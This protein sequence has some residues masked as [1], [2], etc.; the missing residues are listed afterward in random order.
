MKT[1][2][3]HHHTA[4]TSRNTTGGPASA[5]FSDLGNATIFFTMAV[6][7]TSRVHSGVVSVSP[8]SFPMRQSSI[9]NTFKQQQRI[10][11]VRMMFHES[12]RTLPIYHQLSQRRQTPR[13]PGGL[14]DSCQESCCQHLWDS[15]ECTQSHVSTTYKTPSPRMRF[16]SDN[17]N[18]QRHSRSLSPANRS[19]IFHRTYIHANLQYK[20]SVDSLQFSTFHD[21]TNLSTKKDDRYVTF[22][23]K[24][25][26][27]SRENNNN[28]TNNNKPT[29]RYLS[30]CEDFVKSVQLHKKEQEKNKLM[31]E[32]LEYY[33]RTNH[34]LNYY[35]HGDRELQQSESVLQHNKSLVDGFLT[36][37]GK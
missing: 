33:K 35:L 30:A 12:S 32:R 34:I 2:S 24:S 29:K 20:T 18:E 7:V 9:V 28:N 25:C 22:N 5:R 14:S 11:L 26:Q 15:S 31:Q 4:S 37:D 17:F 16:K 21:D 3:S 10:N 27:S 6:P 36:Y 8:F 19:Q 23:Y 1:H 13:A